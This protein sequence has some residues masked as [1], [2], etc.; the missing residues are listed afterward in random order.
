MDEQFERGPAVVGGRC[1]TGHFCDSLSWWEDRR[2]DT[3]GAVVRIA[4]R[5][6]LTS[7][8]GPGAGAPACGFFRIS[9]HGPE[10]GV[11]TESPRDRIRMYG[12]HMYGDAEG[13]TRQ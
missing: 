9:D 7:C 11:L 13:P 8:A 12:D 2:R 6:G 4:D 5:A 1:G 3:A 10:C